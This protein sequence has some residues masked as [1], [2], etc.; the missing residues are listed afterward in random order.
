LHLIS[1]WDGTPNSANPVAAAFLIH[2]V[3]ITTGSNH[4]G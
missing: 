3:E 4:T 1:N 2:V